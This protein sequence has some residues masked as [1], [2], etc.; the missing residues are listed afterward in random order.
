MRGRLAG[1]LLMISSLA[2]GVSGAGA[3]TDADGELRGGLWRDFDAAT[4]EPLVVP[5][6]EP[7]FA[8][9]GAESW[10]GLYRDFFGKRAKSS[11]AGTGLCHGSPTQAGAKQ[12]NFVCADVDGCFASMR[13]SSHP[14]PRVLMGPLVA[15]SA[16]AAPES[17]NLFKA[18]RYL[19]P[20]GVQVPNLNMP[21][22][23]SDFYFKNG[24]IQRMQAWIR[25]GAQN[26]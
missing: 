11:C 24:D 4:P 10:R 16:K 18:I 26:D 17:A 21:L 13:G 20:E 2:I 19:T 25:N 9:A 6:T 15:D 23:P 7:T 8:D 22:S 14:E 12:S 5:I 3:C 1:T